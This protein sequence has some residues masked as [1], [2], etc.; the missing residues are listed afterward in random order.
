MHTHPVEGEEAVVWS[1][2]TMRKREVLQ[3]LA[4]GKTSENIAEI[5]HIS[6]YTVYAHR[7][8]IMQKTNATN[9]AELIRIAIRERLVTISG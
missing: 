3:L 8:N 1:S 7:R 5:L 4:E 9:L 6:A 2:L